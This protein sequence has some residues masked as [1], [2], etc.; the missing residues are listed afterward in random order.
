MSWTCSL[1]NQTQEESKGI[2][3]KCNFIFAC[4]LCL[5][6]APEWVTWYRPSGW[7]AITKA[8]TRYSIS[9]LPC[10]LEGTPIQYSTW[11]GVKG[12][13]FLNCYYYCWVQKQCYL[14]LKISHSQHISRKH[15]EFSSFYPKTT[16]A[17]FCH[18]CFP[19][20]FIYQVLLR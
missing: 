19:T 7:L 20:P 16:V 2:F 11:G 12:I 9:W 8:G 13:L 10:C 1:I 15:G 5:W 17:Y 14:L 18:I 4:K 3:G 6:P